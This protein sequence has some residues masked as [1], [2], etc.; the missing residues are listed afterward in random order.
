MANYFK[1]SNRYKKSYVETQTFTRPIADDRVQSF[2]MSDTW[3]FGTVIVKTDLSLEDFKQQ[4]RADEEDG[5]FSSED[6]EIYDY[7]ETWDG[8]ALDFNNFHNITEE[9]VESLYEKD[10]D[11][12]SAH[13][14]SYDDSWVDIYGPLDVEDVTEEYEVKR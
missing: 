10:T 5:Y 8:C 11:F 7:E 9:E 13:G 3:R 6:H 4:T 1:V 14:F 2:T 12:E